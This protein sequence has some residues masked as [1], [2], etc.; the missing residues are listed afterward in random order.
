MNGGEIQEKIFSLIL[1]LPIR[2]WD[3]K[4]IFDEYFKSQKNLLKG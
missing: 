1:K 2:K 3:L 4:F